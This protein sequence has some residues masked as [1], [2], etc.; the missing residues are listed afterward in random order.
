M[1][2]RLT[3]SWFQKRILLKKKKISVLLHLS[4]PVISCFFFMI[5]LDIVHHLLMFPLFGCFPFTEH[6]LEVFNYFIGVEMHLSQWWSIRASLHRLF[7]IV[8]YLLIIPLWESGD[9]KLS[10]PA[11]KKYWK[12]TIYAPQ[13]IIL[14][15]FNLQ[16]VKQTYTFCQTP[17]W[18]TALRRG[19]LGA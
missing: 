4:F 6:P 18:P 11:L 19:S 17:R 8:K 13:G 1:R 10:Q 14:L 7:K 3:F 9:K 5:F 2:R 12:K 16:G 15:H